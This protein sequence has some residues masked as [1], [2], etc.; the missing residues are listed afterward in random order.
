MKPNI[1]RQGAIKEAISGA[2]AARRGLW[3]RCG[4]K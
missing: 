4:T 2:M 3:G 1:A